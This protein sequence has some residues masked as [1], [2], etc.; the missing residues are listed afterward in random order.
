MPNHSPTQK[1]LAQ[2]INKAFL[3][4]KVAR[5]YI[6]AFKTQLKTL[7]FHIDTDESEANVRD[8]LRDFL[9]EIGYKNKPY[10][11]NAV[12]GI[13]TVLGQQCRGMQNI[14]R[15]LGQVFQIKQNVFQIKPDTRQN[16]SETC[17]IK[18]KISF[19]AKH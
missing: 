10:K 4:E 11:H 13:S 19:F 1:S 15:G 7:L 18:Q 17:K 5:P 2:A 3:K 16:Q 8:H 6:E 9:N 12:H 14:F